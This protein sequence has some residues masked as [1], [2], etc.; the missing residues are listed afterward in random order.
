MSNVMLAEKARSEAESIYNVGQ[1][2]AA[3]RTDQ[4]VEDQDGDDDSGIFGPMMM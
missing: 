4:M 1:S 3:T 2:K